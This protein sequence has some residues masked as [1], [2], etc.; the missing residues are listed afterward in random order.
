MRRRIRACH[1][2]VLT[3]ACIMLPP[4]FGAGKRER[5]GEGQREREGEGGRGG[6]REGGR[7]VGR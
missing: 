2:I 5:E 7:E 1:M 3:H 6:G 4:E